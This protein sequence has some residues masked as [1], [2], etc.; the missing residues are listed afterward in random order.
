MKKHI[1]SA[2]TLT[3]V[4]SVIAILLA[5]VNII[6][7]PIIEQRKTAAANEAL[8][9]VMPKG[10]EFVQMEDLSA[11]TLPETVTKIY[12]EKNGGYVF[13]LSTTGYA[14][15]LVIMC[16]VNKEGTVTGA[17]CIS[18]NETNKKELTYGENF[19]D[20]DLSAAQ[21]VDTIASSTK[22]TAA[23]KGA[24]ID[25]INSA[26]ILMGESVDIRS[27]EEKLM[28]S[29]KE[30]L[31]S[32]DTFEA[33]FKVTHLADITKVYKAKNNKGYIFI[34]KETLVATD[35]NGVVLS[36]VD[37]KTK[38]DVSSAAKKHLE[39]KT[40][41]IDLSKY[42]GLPSVVEKAYSVDGGG[43]VFELKA[44][45]FGIK[46]D[47]YYN[48]SGEY[49]KIKVSVAES[50]EIIDC[51]TLYQK[52]SENYGATCGDAKFYSQF[53]GKT[54]ETYKNIDG[55]SGATITTNGYTSAIGSVFDALN[56]IK[57]GA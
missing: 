54:K 31:P 30:A 42:S 15:G 23:Y 5:G 55:I 35:E 50:G 52:E 46:G 28:D 22:T 14:S 26:K 29:L 12:S 4:C 25:A 1:K 3:I 16:G 36:D 38:T 41:E 11:Y 37:S 47:S 43:Y 13:E 34:Y 17:V 40:T 33:E 2:L 39:A 44:S 8:L 21:K 7:Y 27:E 32:A 20:A 56:I 51:V 9:K 53:S 45:G 18:S 24:V 57:G 49:I 10:E 6:T 48:P 19:K